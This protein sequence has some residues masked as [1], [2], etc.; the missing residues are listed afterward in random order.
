MRAFFARCGAAGLLH[1]G[2]APELRHRCLGNDLRVKLQRRHA[3]VIV[4][5]VFSNVFSSWITHFLT[6]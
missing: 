5:L 1:A 2:N 4:R 6:Q 3:G